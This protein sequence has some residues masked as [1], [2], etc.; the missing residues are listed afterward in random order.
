MASA[1]EKVLMTAFARLTSRRRT[2]R[3]VEMSNKS[4]SS[5]DT[6]SFLTLMG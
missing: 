4:G 2:M 1:R 3:A 5:L 6:V